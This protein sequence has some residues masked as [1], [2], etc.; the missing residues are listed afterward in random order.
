MEV[1]GKFVLEGNL[2][3]RGNPG[4]NWTTGQCCACIIDLNAYRRRDITNVFSGS[5]DC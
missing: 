2:K 4:M 3:C 5:R 1:E